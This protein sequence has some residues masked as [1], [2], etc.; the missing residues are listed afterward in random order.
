MEK[1]IYAE[2]YRTLLKWLRDQ[3]KRRGLT[4]RDL[5]A[6]LDVHHS[7]IGRVEKGE[8]R[9][10]VMEFTRVCEKIGCDALEG[11]QLVIAPVG[12]ERP[13]K[14]AESKPTYRA[15]RPTRSKA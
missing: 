6:R 8:R 11:L 14:V 1:T 5:G 3:R 4:M 12:E 2:E 15:R 9:L 13:R 10:D 7:W